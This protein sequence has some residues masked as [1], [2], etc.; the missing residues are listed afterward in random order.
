MQ[1]RATYETNAEFLRET[2]RRLEAGEVTID[3]LENLTAEMAKAMKFCQ[4]RLTR[5]RQSVADTMKQQ[6]P[7]SSQ[8]AQPSPDERH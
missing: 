7:Q 3:E 4:E 1:D 6:A 2:V 8:S 5:T